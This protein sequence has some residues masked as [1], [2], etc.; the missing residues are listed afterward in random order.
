MIPEVIYMGGA[1]FRTSLILSFKSK[2][3]WVENRMKS[4]AYLD[5]PADERRVMFGSLWDIA[6]SEK[7]E[8][9]KKGK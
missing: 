8:P 1:A 6:N 4:N 9:K 5:H 2:D 3:E 7:P